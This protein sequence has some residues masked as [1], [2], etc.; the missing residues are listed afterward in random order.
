MVDFGMAQEPDHMPHQVLFFDRK[1]E[2]PCPYDPDLM[3]NPTV[4]LMCDFVA[5]FPNYVS[6]QHYEGKE[7]VVTNVPIDDIY[8]MYFYRNGGELI[9]A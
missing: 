6:C 2:E 5:V 4:S 9:G 8:E 7:K 3:I 1:V